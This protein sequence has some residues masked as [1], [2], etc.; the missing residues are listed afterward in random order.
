MGIMHTT[1]IN[2]LGGALY[3]E[4]PHNPLIARRDY[5]NQWIIN[6]KISVRLAYRR[7]DPVI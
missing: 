5:E 7:R 3:V 2:G 1:M 6:K 4:P